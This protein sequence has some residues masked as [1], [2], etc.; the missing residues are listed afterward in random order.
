MSKKA[1]IKTKFVMNGKTSYIESDIFGRTG[2]Q[3]YSGF[4]IHGDTTRRS[5]RRNHKA[6]ARRVMRG[7]W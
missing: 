5:E 2:H 6:E 7:D 1:T 4:G 3:S